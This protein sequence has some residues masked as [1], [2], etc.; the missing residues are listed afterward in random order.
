MR[1]VIGERGRSRSRSLVIADGRVTER[2]RVGVDL[3]CVREG[4]TESVVYEDEDD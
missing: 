1:G 4:A 2:S 3:E